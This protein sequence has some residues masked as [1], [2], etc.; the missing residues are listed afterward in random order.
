MSL[1]EM[2][3][4]VG[5]WF[6]RIFFYAIST[7]SHKAFYAWFSHSVGKC[8]HWYVLHRRERCWLGAVLK[9]KRDAVNQM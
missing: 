4:Y 3:V 2:F 1:D 8:G 7:P 6:D 5:L 9:V